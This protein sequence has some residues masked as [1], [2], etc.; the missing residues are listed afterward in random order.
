[1]RLFPVFVFTA[2]LCL[3]SPSF[4]GD[5]S[6]TDAE[7]LQG[8]WQAVTINNEGRSAPEELSRGF[9]ILIVGE[10]MQMFSPLG[11]AEFS[12]TLDPTKKPKA[13]SLE[14][15]GN[16]FKYSSAIYELKGDELKLCLSTRNPRDFLTEFSAPD[17]SGIALV[18]LKR[19]PDTKKD[20]EAIQGTWDL[21]ER[22]WPGLLRFKVEGNK[23]T[24]VTHEGEK[25]F[26]FTLDP[27]QKPKAA[28]TAISGDSVSCIYELNGDELTVCLSTNDKRPA[29]FT[30]KNGHLLIKVRHTIPKEITGKVVAAR[31]GER[32]TIWV[33]RQRNVDVR[34][35][36]IDAPE[37]SQA[38]GTQSWKRLGELMVGKTVTVKTRGAD[39]YNRILGE[40]L[41]PVELSNVNLMLVSEGLAWHDV[42][43]AK[44]RHDIREAE[45]MARRA[46]SGLWS[47][48]NPVAPW[49][50]RKAKAAKAKPKAE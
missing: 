46:K 42:Q 43:F 30:E 49:E 34:L 35:F 19:A 4:G 36:G 6:K 28:F 44:D 7:G 12:F 13:I 25:E 41:S 24:V 15:R 37:R 20:M 47:D 8:Y 26:F 33:D 31:D 27:T 10:K 39:D 14:G 22:P 2:V 48:P 21:L 45:D 9:G 5:E 17:G 18:T 29:E 16:D 50:F 1:M 23:V 3:A 32:L 38:F 40:V 11:N